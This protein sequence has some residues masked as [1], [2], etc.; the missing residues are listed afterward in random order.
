MD[1]HRTDQRRGRAETPSIRR[2]FNASASA[3]DVRV[4][5]NLLKYRT[6]TLYLS[7]KRG[8]FFRLHY[9]SVSSSNMQDRRIRV[10]RHFDQGISM[11]LCYNQAQRYLL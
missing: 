1:D 7:L 9:R 6:V 5:L 2:N 11:F 10:F 4:N 8:L 3:S